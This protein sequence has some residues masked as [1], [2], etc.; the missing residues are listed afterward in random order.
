MLKLVL[1]IIL[2]STSNAFDYK[3]W[4]H[5]RK[6][7]EATA[8]GKYYGLMQ[9]NASWPGV[10]IPRTIKE[11]SAAN[12]YMV[13]NKAYFHS[14]RRTVDPRQLPA[15]KAWQMRQ[16]MVGYTGGARY[17]KPRQR[18]QTYSDNGYEYM[19]PNPV[20]TDLDGEPI[21]HK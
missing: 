4:I 18:Y 16:N 6:H 15:F 12:P 8:K 1:T 9:R 2:I 21:T 20:D 11:T 13:R 7:F 19:T 10:H 14:R 17:G 3:Q 5:G